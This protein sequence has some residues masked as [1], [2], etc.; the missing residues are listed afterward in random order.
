MI[1]PK[2]KED[3]GMITFWELIFWHNLIKNIKIMML[4]ISMIVKHYVRS[5]IQ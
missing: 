3:I 1:L 5:H 2:K 4:G